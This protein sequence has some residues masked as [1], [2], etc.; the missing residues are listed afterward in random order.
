MTL[1]DI[2]AQL[3]DELSTIT[4]GGVEM[5]FDDNNFHLTPSTCG[6]I[7]QPTLE[8]VKYFHSPP[9]IEQSCHS[10][11]MYICVI[12]SQKVFVPPVNLQTICRPLC[13]PK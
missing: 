2:Y 3:R 9:P 12:I 1:E 13:S 11:Y 6:N 5:Y 7:L 10:T 8:C 4:V